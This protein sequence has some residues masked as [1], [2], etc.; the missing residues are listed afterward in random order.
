M[1]KLVSFLTILCAY[2]SI[3]HRIHSLFYVSFFVCVFT[4]L[5]YSEKKCYYFNH[6][7]CVRNM[8]LS[9]ACKPISWLR[10]RYLRGCP[11]KKMEVYFTAQCFICFRYPENLCWETDFNH[12]FPETLWCVCFFF[13]CFNSDKF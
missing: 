11:W 9:R 13:V 1:Y 2:P 10:I 4:I 3:P 5:F 7:A 12:I 6:K 8:P